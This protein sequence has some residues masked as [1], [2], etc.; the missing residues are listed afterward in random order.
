[1]IQRAVGIAI[2]ARRRVE[3]TAH[4]LRFLEA[5]STASN[6]WRPMTRLWRAPPAPRYFGALEPIRRC[7]RTT[8]ARSGSARRAAGLL[9]PDADL[10]LARAAAEA[11]IPFVLSTTSNASLEAVAAVAGDHAWF[12]LY[13]AR[14][15]SISAD[16]IRRA[17]DA[18]IGTLMVT[19]DTPL[20]S[21][22]ERNM[23]NGFGRPLRMRPP[24]LLEALTHPGW[25]ARY[26]LS[27]GTP[28][29]GNWTPYAGAGAGKD[30]VAAFSTTQTPNRQTWDDL[31]VT[32]RLWPH[33]LVVKGIMHQDDAV[34]AVERRRY[35]VLQS[36][37]TRARSGAVQ[38]RR[39]SVRSRCGRRTCR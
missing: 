21:K 26:L 36:W 25:I 24:I 16:M 20:H 2:C 29:F 23:R 1:M 14:D 39:L 3:R 13:G 17:I 27:G 12:Q 19:V 32:R 37:R 5:A 28:D 31:A 9:R 11:R 38:L 6:A 33:K 10:M 18:G 35:R 8:A 22:R 7:L 4:H 30:A 34:N 15:R